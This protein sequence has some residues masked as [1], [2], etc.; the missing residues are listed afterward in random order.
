MI[1]LQ[2]TIASCLVERA[3]SSSNAHRN[4]CITKSARCS[5]NALSCRYAWSTAT[6]TCP[7]PSS[8][9]ISSSWTW[10]FDRV[11]ARLENASSC[12]CVCRQ[13]QNS[14]AS[15]LSSY[16]EKIV[17]RSLNASLFHLP[18]YLYPDIA[19]LWW[20]IS[21]R[22]RQVVRGG[23]CYVRAFTLVSFDSYLYT[24]CRTS[25]YCHSLFPRVPGFV[26]YTLRSVSCWSLFI[27]TLDS[28][29]LSFKVILRLEI[30]GSLSC[31][32]TVLRRPGM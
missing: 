16:G 22:D 5:W 2:I 10:V 13:D 14:A 3:G 9:R 20:A 27:R 15:I 32:F 17:E 29:R 8:W 31:M 25:S 24:M 7:S 12:F 26:L 6:P 4:F 28:D 23:F 1:Q 21:Q 30:V 18:T 19:E 11:C